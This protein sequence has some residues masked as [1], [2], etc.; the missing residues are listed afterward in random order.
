MVHLTTVGSHHVNGVAVLHSELV[1]RQLMQSSMIWPALQVRRNVTN[2]VTPRR[3][4]KSCNQPLGEVLDNVGPEWVT[5]MDIL[6]KLEDQQDD[7][8]LLEKIAETKLIG[9]HKLN[10]YIN[11]NLGVLVDPSSMFDVHVKR[12]HEYKRQHLKRS[13]EVVIQYLRIKNG[14][15]LCSQNR[16][17]WW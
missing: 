14:A 3:W 12:I 11:N 9:K 16:N 4:L 5:N 17:L 15:Q 1:K 6:R 2:G 7:S 13:L 8:N 10:S